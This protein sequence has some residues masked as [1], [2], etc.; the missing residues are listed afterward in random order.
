MLITLSDI[1]VD[2]TIQPRTD[3]NQSRVDDF[4]NI[5]RYGGTLEPVAVFND[6]QIYWLSDGFHRLAA[7]RLVGAA[8]IEVNVHIGS[9]RDAILFAIETNAKHGIP[10]SLDERKKAATFLLSDPEWSMWSSRKIG[11]ICGLDHKTVQKIRAN[12]SHP[13]LLQSVSREIPQTQ[14][15]TASAS[16]PSEI[17]KAIRRGKIYEIDTSNIGRRS[18]HSQHSRPPTMS[19]KDAPSAVRIPL[20]TSF[21]LSQDPNVIPIRAEI[22]PSF[23]LLEVAVEEQPLSGDLSQ[24]HLTVVSSGPVYAVPLIFKQMQTHPEFAE[25]VLQ[26]AQQLA[27]GADFSLIS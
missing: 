26:Q 5:L 19:E 20:S 12:Y 18:Q 6:G 3:F 25:I 13:Q 10:L 23:S 8:Q 17:R 21:Q 9:F 1:V 7:H 15:F 14:N 2:T 22:L 11:Q 24:H 16:C 27:N 4:I